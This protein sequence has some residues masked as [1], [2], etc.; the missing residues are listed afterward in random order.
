MFQNLV[1]FHAKWRFCEEKTKILQNLLFFLNK[2]LT[3]KRRF[4][5]IFFFLS[6]F[7][8]KKKVSFWKP[9][10]VFL[11]CLRKKKIPKTFFFCR[12]MQKKEDFENLVLTMQKMQ[13][14]KILPFWVVSKSWKILRIS[15]HVLKHVVERGI[16]EGWECLCVHLLFNNATQTRKLRLFRENQLSGNTTM[17]TI[18]A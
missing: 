4:Y 2:I 12:K 16:C 3:R 15:M 8:W 11:H 18:R 10:F 17:Q 9:S 13:K 14:N 5:N 6:A 1:N 7:F